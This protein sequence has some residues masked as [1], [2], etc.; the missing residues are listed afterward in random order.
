MSRKISVFTSAI[1]TP[2]TLR[3]ITMIWPALPQSMLLVQSL[4]FP[5][6]EFETVSIPVGGMSLPVPTHVYKPGSWSFT[7]PDNILSTV[8]LELWNAYYEQ[9]LH[10][11]GLV[12]G[13][14]GDTFNFSSVGSAVSG[15]LKAGSV[16]TGS[17]AT[18]CVLG[19]SFIRSISAVD[20]SNGGNATEAVQWRV[21]VNYSYIRKISIQS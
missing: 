20:F 1:P 4:T 10:D 16:V 8:R 6:E 18:G 12:L 14:L 5:T 11:I 7:V 13:N 3:D 21:T 9:G 15:L 2:L 19:G 17:L